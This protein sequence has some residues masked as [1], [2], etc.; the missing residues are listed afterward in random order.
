[1]SDL[2]VGCYECKYTNQGRRLFE[3]SHYPLHSALLCILVGQE[4]CLSGA[5]SIG[6][7][8]QAPKYFLA[9]NYPLG[10]SWSKMKTESLLNAGAKVIYLLL[11]GL[12]WALWTG[13]ISHP[14]TFVPSAEMSRTT[15]SPSNVIAGAM[16]Y[17][18][19][20]LFFKTW[21]MKYYL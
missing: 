11:Y 4:L 13:T 8:I 5:I 18:C 2:G 10:L 1:M 14:L 7:H 3:R 9:K 17:S 21:S 6:A 15:W 12:T 19:W 20:Y 16:S